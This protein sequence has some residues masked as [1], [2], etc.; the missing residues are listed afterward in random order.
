MCLLHPAPSVQPTGLWFSLAF[1]EHD[2]NQPLTAD[3]CTVVLPTRY[4]LKLQQ[5]YQDYCT[6]VQI[7]PILRR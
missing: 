6:T 1:V 4:A 5:I 3:L 7:M 2:E